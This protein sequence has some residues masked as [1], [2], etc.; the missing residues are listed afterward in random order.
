MI[1]FKRRRFFPERQYRQ[2]PRW[3]MWAVFV[4]LALVFLLFVRLFK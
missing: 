1:Q 4:L 2:L 3:L